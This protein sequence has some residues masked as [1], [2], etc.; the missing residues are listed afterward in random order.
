VTDRGDEWSG[1]ALGILG[2]ATV[3]P[4]RRDAACR[5]TKLWDVLA[6]AA[7]F[8]L[9]A[10]F[11][12]L[13]L[14]VVRVQLQEKGFFLRSRHFVWMVPASDLL[15]FLGLGLA[16]AVALM[17]F[18][19]R[20]AYR[21]ALA[22]FLFAAVLC[23][24]MLVRGL[25]LVTCVL[26]A[27]GFAVRAAPWLE[28]RAEGLRRVVRR[29][30]PILFA[31]ITAL[32]A[33]VFF[34]DAR[35][36]VWR[37]GDRTAVAGRDLNVLLVVLDTVRADRLSLYGYDRETTPNLK[38]LAER[39]VRFD[40]ARAAASWTLP[41]HANIFT[42]RWPSE[43]DVERRGW[44]DGEYPTLAEHLRDSGYATAGFVANPF[45]CGHE[46][47]LARGFQVY[48]DYPITLGEVFRSSSLGWF[49]TRTALRAQSMT[50]AW[51]P[52]GSVRDVDLDFSRKDASTVNREFLDW[53]AK[54]GPRPYFAFLN[55]FD[56]HD[57]YVLPSGETPRFTPE[58]LSNRASTMLRDWQ[59]IDKKTL[60][61]DEAQVARDAYDDCLAA[62]DQR[63]G[64]LFD[65][66]SERGELDRTLVIL[67]S[68]HGE[69]FGDH[70]DFGHGLS[71]Y[72][73][74]VHVPLLVSL[75]GRVPEGQIVSQAVSLRDLPATVLDVL[76]LSDGSPFPGASLATTWR[77]ASVAS[78]QAVS[79]PFSELRGPVD[80]RE[81]VEH[82]DGRK[83]LK[84]VVVER[85]AYIRRGDGREELYDLGVD[86]GETSDESQNGAF[87][88]V[89][90]SCRNALGEVLS[91]FEQSATR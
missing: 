46:S 31:A 22:M 54:T 69:Q 38:R 50:G 32:G 40:H 85:H 35:T 52:A 41:S 88:D 86:P 14:L 74:E 91:T 13:L 4:E 6:T 11:L 71:L 87:T 56:A 42:A 39:G 37:R 62:L 18:A 80:E 49:L 16:A 59:R 48:A 5:G 79:P 63:I 36:R 81:V 83:S 82:A 45:F 30:L 58:T 84:A 26:L 33:I 90:D 21:L 65:A 47:G 34:Q 64:M 15:L 1:R 43:L 9:T 60:S 24:L 73:E 51:R 20:S 2:D 78:A 76:G 44:L 68:D 28:R 66:L 17:R 10:G 7:W 19:G 55:F 77:E 72:G 27:G 12:E 89:L 3:E 75:P 53:L 29:S 67:T 8:G 61:P 23:Q 57:P 25:H 70:G